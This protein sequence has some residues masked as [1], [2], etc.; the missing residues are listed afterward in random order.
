MRFQDL[1][2]FSRVIHAAIEQSPRVIIDS[3]NQ[4]AP[5]VLSPL[6]V[7]GIL[8]LTHHLVDGTRNT[9]PIPS[10]GPIAREARR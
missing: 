2:Y 3:N 4:C 10:Y 7:L 8:A 6:L 9:V 1:S 5:H